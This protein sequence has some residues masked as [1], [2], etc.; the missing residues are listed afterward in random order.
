MGRIA[1]HDLAETAPDGCTVVIADANATIAARVTRA[2]SQTHRVV[3]R[4]ASVDAGEPRRVA[5]LLRRVNAFAILNATHHRFNIPVMDAALAA[6]AHYCDLGGLF[7]HTRRQLPH[8]AAWKRAG[9]LAL[10]GIGA[11]PGIVNVL[12]RSAADTMDVV[13]EIHVAVAGVDRTRGRPRSPFGVSYSVRTLFEEASQPAAVFSGGRLRFEPPMS[14]AI[15]TRFPPP[16]G[17]QSP[18][19][20]LHSEVATLP[21]TYRTKGLRECSFRIALPPETVERLTVL[22]DLGLLSA[23]P[24]R[25]GSAVITPLEWLATILESEARPP[26]R[27]VPDE[28]EILRVVVRGRRKGTA[29]EDTVDCHV[30]GNRAWRVGIDIDT[31][32]PPSIAMQMLARGEITARGVVAPEQAIP[33]KSF[34]RELHRRGMRIRTRR[35]PWSS[36]G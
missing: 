15:E 16:V 14:G 8:H 30:R 24:I 5:A 4:S 33:A 36:L 1:A 10:V 13:R 29:V 6:R 12:A 23:I 32:C 31:G 2:L 7:H 28:Y 35:R 20:T 34:F 26:W 25:V 11:A 3:L 27:G 19:L 21:R 22:R 18:A 9:R 17:W